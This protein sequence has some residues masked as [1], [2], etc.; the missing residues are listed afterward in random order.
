MGYMHLDVAD[1]AQL[2]ASGQLQDVVLHEMGHILGIGTLWADRNY[3]L[4]PGSA[5]PR[6]TGTAG[7][8]G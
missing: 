5:N 7:V 1:V 8:Q 4:N 6:Y 2:A 3:V